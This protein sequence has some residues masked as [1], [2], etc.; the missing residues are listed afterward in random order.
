[1]NDIFNLNDADAH[2]LSRYLIEDSQNDYVYCDPNNE[3]IRSVIKSI[4]KTAVGDY[5][6]PKDFDK[7]RKNADE[8]I[9]KYHFN[10]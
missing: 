7:L 5:E 3:N 1:M 9:S 8:L 6:L 10:L 4:I 2:T